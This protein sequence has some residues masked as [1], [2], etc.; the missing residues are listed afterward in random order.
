MADNRNTNK[1]IADLMNIPHVGCN[2]HKLNLEVKKMITESP[3]L[4]STIDSV[5]L[6][7]KSCTTGLRNRALLR[8][9]TDLS[10]VLNNQARWS[11]VHFMLKRYMRIRDALLSVGDSSESSLHLNRSTAFKTKAALYSSQ[12][13]EINVVTNE[14]QKRGLN[15][16]DSRYLLDDLIDAVENGRDDMSSP[17][18]Q[19]VLGT[20]YISGIAPIVH[21]PDFESGDIKIQKQKVQ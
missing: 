7:M 16:S 2:N 14:L 6:T 11:S 5:H 1:R 13:E 3:S 4:Q 17:F 20:T 9:I 19:C 8:N 12:F 18:F 10:P 15:L 21:S